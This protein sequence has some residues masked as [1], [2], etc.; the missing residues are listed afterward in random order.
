[1]A[2]NTSRN[3]PTSSR[4]AGKKDPEELIDSQAT[5][6]TEDDLTRIIDAIVALQTV[7]VQKLQRLQRQFKL[8]TSVPCD[9][10]NMQDEQDVKMGHKSDLREN[11]DELDPVKK[12]IKRE[13]NKQSEKKGKELETVIDDINMNDQALSEQQNKIGQLKLSLEAA[14]K[15]VKSLNKKVMECQVELEAKERRLKEQEKAIEDIKQAKD[16]ALI[17]LSHEIGR[18]V[19]EGNPNITDL[20]DHKRPTKLGEIYSELYDNEWTN[21][22]E[23]LT[24][25]LKL[26]GE[27]AVELLL[28]ILQESSK[29]ASDLSQ[30]NMKKIEKLLLGSSEEPTPNCKRLL[31]EARKHVNIEKA[32]DHIQAYVKTLAARSD[33]RT[34]LKKKQVEIYSKKCFQLCWL[35]SIQDPPVVLS[36]DPTRGSCFDTNIYRLFT[37]SGDKF[38]YV[39]WPALLL[40]N[41]GPI[42]VKGVAQPCLAPEANSNP[43]VCRFTTKDD[44]SFEETSEEKE[45]SSASGSEKLKKKQDGN[46]TMG[47]AARSLK[48]GPRLEFSQTCSADGR[49]PITP[50][51]VQG[52]E[53]NQIFQSMRG[54]VSKRFPEHV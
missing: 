11:Y 52:S 23:V 16:E 42:I 1:M 27:K 31:R 53:L 21:A 13:S 32:E 54:K 20:S 35:M 6:S 45:S 3:S 4:G 15:D 34:Y 33:E 41:D 44:K 12:D 22:F 5:V 7:D 28:K 10:K 8:Q 30:S 40:Y 9:L 19:S 36:K 51:D 14:N 37:H 24:Q 17:R 47:N 50:K 2:S 39:V 29:H 18:K 48:S 26:N 43:S 25:T 49:K 38:D 46:Q